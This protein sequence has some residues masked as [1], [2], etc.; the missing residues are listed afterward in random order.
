MSFQDLGSL[1]EFIA[2]IA[3]VA[4]LVYLAISIRHNSKTVAASVKQELGRTLLEFNSH[5]FND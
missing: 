3:T 1:G 4:T 2:A 5:I